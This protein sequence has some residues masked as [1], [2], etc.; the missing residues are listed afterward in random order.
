MKVRTKRNKKPNHQVN[1]R[2]FK[3]PIITNHRESTKFF[4]TSK[5]C[6][7]LRNHLVQQRTE[8][9]TKIK[10]QLKSGQQH[11]KYLTRADQYASIPQL[12]KEN[13]DL[14]KVHSQVLQN[15]AERV[16]K[17]YK[18]FLSHIKNKSAGKKSPPGVVEPR[19]YK[20]FTFPQYGSSAFIRSGILHLSKLGDFKLRDY[21]KLKG[22]PKSINI[23]FTQGQW[24]AVISC[25]IRTEEVYRG[26]KDIMDL[27]DSGGDPGLSSLLTLADGTIFNPPKALKLNL[28]KLRAA[29]K[30][31]SRKFE[32]RKK[33]YKIE[34]F[35]RKEAGE[36]AQLPLKEIPYSNRLKKSIKQVAKLHTK[37][38]NI[39]DYHHKKL[40]RRLEKTV[41]CLAMEEHSVQF[42]IRKRKQARAASDRAIYSFKQA[43]KSTMGMR[44]IP[45]GTVR[46]GIGGNSQTCLCNMPVPKDLKDRMH[47]CPNCGLVAQRDVVSA[48][49]VMQVGLG[50]SYL[51]VQEDKVLNLE[52]VKKYKEELIKE[53]KNKL[54]VVMAAGHASQG[55]KSQIRGEIKGAKTVKLA[56]KQRVRKLTSE[57]SVKRE[58]ELPKGYKTE[59]EESTSGAKTTSELINKTAQSSLLLPSEA[60]ICLQALPVSENGNSNS[61]TNFSS[62]KHRP[63]GR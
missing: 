21:R 18:E 56:G 45:V 63:S 4:D 37:V 25:E 22:K 41:R 2:A 17:G 8:N 31:M 20:S 5:I 26:A 16:D 10:E 38:G 50:S 24:W 9:R 62:G 29:Q 46:E 15:V 11:D 3:F 30:D 34:N 54:N 55:I 40:A 14:L 47:N 58:P 12:I 48:N 59:G 32:E 49:I 39:R 44:Y 60:N 33:A 52:E 43:V 1:L 6:C 53:S 28:K 36:E 51:K 57:I 7:F 19:D 42:M 13:K 35:R 61:I 27:P 23:K